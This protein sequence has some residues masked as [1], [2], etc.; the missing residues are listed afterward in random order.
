MW[1]RSL[2]TRVASVV[3]L[4]LA[5]AAIGCGGSAEQ[6]EPR[7]SPPDPG[8]IVARVNGVPITERRLAAMVDADRIRHLSVPGEVPAD[9]EARAEALHLA[10][11][12]ELV[13]QAALDAGID[14][15]EDE[16]DRQLQVVRSQFP[17][18]E[19]FLS[20]L[21]QSGSSTDRIRADARRWL[22]IQAYAGRLMDRLDIDESRVEEM[23]AA[24]RVRALDHE[25]VRVAQ[26][27]VRLRPDS[28]PEERTRAEAK[29]EQAQRRLE[30]GE[31]FADVARRFS[32][33]PL[34]E[35][36]GDMGFIPRGRLLPEFERVVFELPVGTVSDV[37]ETRHGLN[38]VKI[39]ERKGSPPVSREE[40]RAGLL[41]VLARE[42]SGEA[43]REHI[44]A[45][46]RA[47]EI[48]ILD[49][50]LRY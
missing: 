39:L 11:R 48:E 1:H 36:G 2:P 17:T 38:I 26:I 37:F 31:G 21:E 49:R 13:Y 44:D 3:V 4:A 8:R 24:E 50:D 34:A 10:I 25:Q 45:L 43:L 9:P 23:L 16:V 41:L 20:Y 30:S 29:I 14:I 12:A 7:A 47:A 22:L 15:P 18:E 42:Q 35:R 28:S 33:S 40:I 6:S 19:A 5:F 32:E 46:E 27:L